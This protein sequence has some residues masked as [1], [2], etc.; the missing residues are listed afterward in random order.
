VDYQAPGN[1]AHYQTFSLSKGRSHNAIY[2]KT[3][4]H[5]GVFVSTVRCAAPP[6]NRN[7][8]GNPTYRQFALSRL[9]DT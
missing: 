5:G 3:V 9:S 1:V 8:C 6:T 4:Y 2:F 7:P